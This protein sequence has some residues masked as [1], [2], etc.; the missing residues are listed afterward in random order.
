MLRKVFRV[1]DTSETTAIPQS[2]LTALCRSSYLYS[3]QTAG[4]N[5]MKQRGP[6]STR[7]NPFRFQI[8]YIKHIIAVVMST[9]GFTHS[10]YVNF[11]F[12]NNNIKCHSMNKFTEMWFKAVVF[13]IFLLL[14]LMMWILETAGK[15]FD[16]RQIKKQKRWWVGLVFASTTAVG[17]RESYLF[18]KYLLMVWRSLVFYVLSNISR[19]NTFSPLY[20][21]AVSQKSLEEK[22]RTRR[23]YTLGWADSCNF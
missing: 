5:G 1:L 23:R 14:L 8:F 4:T 15:P 12:L 9:L 2:Y 16:C 17:I 21:I 13:F 18:F 10:V 11:Y 6:V 20:C 19:E 3:N 22:L 7:R